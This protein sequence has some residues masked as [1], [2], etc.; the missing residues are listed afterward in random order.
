MVL[1]I[2]L[3][4]DVS[5]CSSPS[6]HT[7]NARLE[8]FVTL[9]NIALMPAKPADTR[10][11]AITTE[12]GYTLPASSPHAWLHQMLNGFEARLPRDRWI[13]KIN[14]R[15]WKEAGAI[16]KAD[17]AQ[18]AAAVPTLFDRLVC[19]STH[20]QPLEQMSYREPAR[21]F[22]SNAY[23]A[24]RFTLEHILRSGSGWDVKAIEALLLSFRRHD[25]LYSPVQYFTQHLLPL[26]EQVA[27]R[28][29]L[30]SLLKSHLEAMRPKPDQFGN[31][32]KAARAMKQR[33]DAL[34]GAEE[35]TGWDSGDPWAAAIQKQIRA[36][37]AAARQ[38]WRAL[39]DHAAQSR[40]ARPGA[41][42]TR[43]AAALVNKIS[44]KDFEQRVSGWFR[45]VTP[46]AVKYR[47][48]WSGKSL[49]RNDEPIRD[50]N[51][52][53]LRGLV[54]MCA[55]R[56][57]DRL[58]APLGDLALVCLK[59]YPGYPAFCATVGNAC[60]DMLSSIKGDAAVAQ[61]SR[62]QNLL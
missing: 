19:L 21:I 9:G 20:M 56:E 62:L 47:R 44:A 45:S 31:M 11:R 42:W 39:I 32:T 5:Q 23:A 26:C 36:L 40:G 17:A 14:P 4:G 1:R 22:A 28:E 25:G 3:N 58:A 43:E 16:T 50:R 46:P 53:I 24:L 6:T 34:L 38:H 27:M 30:S 49:V 12:Y 18:K 52:A 51:A 48:S 7:T 35:R 55:V 29:S 13:Y 37:P 10:S 60:V 8:T 61:L 2:H 57:D 15:R 41:A 33:I 59:K 54:W